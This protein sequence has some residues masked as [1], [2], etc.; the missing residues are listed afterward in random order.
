MATTARKD[1][2]SVARTAVQYPLDP[3]TAREI[4]ESV[5]ILRSQRSLEH[6]VR[7]ESVVP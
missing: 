4:E 1:R 3:L 6:H 5:R 7:F 2:K